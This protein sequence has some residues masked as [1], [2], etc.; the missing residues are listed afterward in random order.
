MPW[1]GSMLC[2]TMVPLMSMSNRRAWLP[3]LAW[4]ILMKVGVL[5][6]R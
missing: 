5:P 4:M 3:F 6:L 2:T 1:W